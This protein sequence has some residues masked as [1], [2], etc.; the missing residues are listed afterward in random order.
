VVGNDRFFYP[1]GNATIVS[2]PI[3]KYDSNTGAIETATTGSGDK[4]H[5]HGSL[6]ENRFL[7]GNAGQDF[8]VG[9]GDKDYVLIGDF[10]PK[11][12]KLI[13]AGNIDDYKFDKTKMF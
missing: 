2:F 8:Y 13:V 9:Q 7:L 6:G 1:L 3:T 12:D 4:D 10:D 5:Y 11:K